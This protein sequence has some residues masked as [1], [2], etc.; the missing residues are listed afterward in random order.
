MSHRNITIHIGFAISHLRGQHRVQKNAEDFIET[1]LVT[2]RIGTRACKIDCVL[3]P[4]LLNKKNREKKKM[5]TLKTMHYVLSTKLKNFRRNALAFASVG[6]R[7][8]LSSNTRRSYKN[9]RRERRKIKPKKKTPGLSVRVVRTVVRLNTRA[10][11]FNC[12]TRRKVKFKHLKQNVGGLNSNLRDRCQILC[13]P[14]LK[15]T[16]QRGRTTHSFLLCTVSRENFQ[17]KTN[18]KTCQLDA[19]MSSV[20]A[21]FEPSCPCPSR[22]D[23]GFAR[24]P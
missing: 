8:F 4:L 19:T 6:A 22:T 12:K 13:C 16:I 21:S 7:V 23:A 17:C 2:F 14:W 20:Y 15:R 1:R 10:L 24:I 5:H 18:S 3:N 9:T 11:E